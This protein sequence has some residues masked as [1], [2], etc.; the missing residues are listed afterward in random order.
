MNCINRNGE[1]GGA[2]NLNPIHIFNIQNCKKW[3]QKR[4]S[5]VIFEKRCLNCLQNEILHICHF[6]YQNGMN[7]VF[8]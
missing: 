5:Y 7:Q 6:T 3:V 4:T 2:T 1:N 8:L